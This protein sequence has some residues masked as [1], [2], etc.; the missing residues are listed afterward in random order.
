MKFFKILSCLFLLIIMSECSKT[1]EVIPNIVVDQYVYLRQPSNINLNAV[2]GWVY[3]TGGSAGIVV[4]RKSND[5]YVAFDRNCTYKPLEKCTITVEQSNILATDACCGS[6]YQLTDGL[7]IKG[8]STISL[9]QYT[10][11]L[12]EVNQVLHIYNY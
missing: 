4:Y 11:V 2:G 1:E 3:L 10:T 5:E 8:P 6:R 7:V 12:D 9:K